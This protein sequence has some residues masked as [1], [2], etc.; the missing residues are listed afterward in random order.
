LLAEPLVFL[1]KSIDF[2][3]GRG[4]RNH[5]RP[6]AAA[7]GRS[8][9]DGGA[10]EGARAARS[11]TVRIRATVAVMAE[12]TVAASGA[13]MAAVAVPGIAG[14]PAVA[15]ATEGTAAGTAVTRRTTPVPPRSGAAG[16]DHGR[17][18]NAVHGAIS[19]TSWR[20]HPAGSAS[21]GLKPRK[22]VS[23]RKGPKRRTD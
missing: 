6:A 16:C 2:G 15:A 20:P 22:C 12:E 11:A 14:V 7:A 21:A 17:Q 13:A 23:R 10:A 18:N 1:A 9:I 19:N 4:N 3:I 5:L 8:D